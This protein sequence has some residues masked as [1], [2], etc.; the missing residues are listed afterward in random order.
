L[1]IDWII[2]LRATK[3]KR[4]CSLVIRS[5]SRARYFCS[6]S[7]RPWNFSGSGRSDLVSRRMLAALD[8]QFA[9]LGLEQR[10]FAADDV[11]QVPALELLVRIL[12]A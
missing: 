8:G 5:S 1:R 12:A 4:V 10:A 9:G 6:T 7:V 2:R 3:V 11:A